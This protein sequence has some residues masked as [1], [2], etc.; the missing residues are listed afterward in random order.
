MFASR[1][2]SLSTRMEEI[3]CSNCTEPILQAQFSLPS[4]NLFLCPYFSIPDCKVWLKKRAPNSNC[5]LLTILTH[6]EPPT[7][8]KACPAGQLDASQQRD[9]CLWCMMCLRPLPN[10]RCRRISFP[11]ILKVSSL[12]RGE[13]LLRR[14]LCWP[15]L[16]IDATIK[17]LAWFLEK[18][19]HCT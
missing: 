17:V 12:P 18:T 3:T 5:L 15:I 13:R 1:V 10:S 19:L 11:W 2:E 7:S 16:I 8:S 9:F 6:R 4:I 14:E